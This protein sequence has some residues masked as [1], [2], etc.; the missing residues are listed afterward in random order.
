M[1]IHNPLSLQLQGILFWPLKTLDT[2][3]TQICM[4]E[5]T[6][7]HKIKINES[8]FKKKNTC[9]HTYQHIL[10]RT[11]GRMP[12]G[13]LRNY[14]R[15]SPIIIIKRSLVLC[16]KTWAEIPSTCSLNRVI[17]EFRNPGDP[18]SSFWSQAPSQFRP[19]LHPQETFVVCI[20]R[21]DYA[22]P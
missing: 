10:F 9:T 14:E 18:L 5:N 19:H 13:Y 20:W 21:R 12:D 17:S 15:C 2:P 11:I 7:A 8:F 16:F 22:Y 4:Q 3:D 6:R 1:V